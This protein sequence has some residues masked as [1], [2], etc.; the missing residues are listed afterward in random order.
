MA[1][2]PAAPCSL[3]VRTSA[4]AVMLAAVLV[5]I[6]TSNAGLFPKLVQGY[7]W[8]AA[9][10]PLVDADVTVNIR[11][12]DTSIRATYTDSTDS[13]GVYSVSFGPGEWELGDTIETISTYLGNQES[14]TTDPITEEGPQWVNVSYAFEIPEF[15]STVGLMIAG[16]LIGAVAV[17]TLV[18]HR[19]R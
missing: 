3:T 18:Y 13:G 15:G 4:V 9:G 1:M 10:T 5:A 11:R 19:K 17:V 6:P 14:N 7:V 16:A 12:P 8:D 2:K